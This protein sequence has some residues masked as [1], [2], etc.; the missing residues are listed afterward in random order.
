MN[1]IVLV[2]KLDN[3]YACMLAI[4]FLFTCKLS[5][6]TNLKSYDPGLHII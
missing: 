3:I 2:R 1:I 5:N 6:A 4:S